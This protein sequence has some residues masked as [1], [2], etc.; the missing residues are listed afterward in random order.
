[1][2]TEGCYLDEIPVPCEESLAH[3]TARI[4]RPQ[5]Y[6][7]CLGANK[8]NPMDNL[9]NQIAIQ[10][11]DAR[12]GKLYRRHKSCRTTSPDPSTPVDPKC[13]GASRRAP[14]GAST[15][16]ASRTAI[17]GTV[18]SPAFRGISSVAFSKTG[19]MTNISRVG[20]SQ[21]VSGAESGYTS[22]IGQPGFMY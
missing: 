4:G 19:L 21:I 10:E 2:A 14:A 17:R 7:D 16:T 6:R 20:G 12:V 8:I 11:L 18:G 22:R 15:L 5:A 9:R 13:P 1:M 3:L